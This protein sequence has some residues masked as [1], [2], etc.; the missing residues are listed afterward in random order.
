V[1][2]APAQPQVVFAGESQMDLI[3]YELDL[4]PVEFRLR[5]IIQEGDVWPHNG[6]FEGVMTRQVLELLR[7]RSDWSTPTA[8][9]RR[10]QASPIVAPARTPLCARFWPKSCICRTRPSTL[11]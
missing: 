7:D 9:R 11:R 5:N 4:D 8:P 1:A 10:S 3:A 2:R 6:K